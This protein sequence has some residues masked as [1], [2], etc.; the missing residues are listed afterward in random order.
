MVKMCVTYLAL[1]QGLA[2]AKASACG[3]P[4]KCEDFESAAIVR[5]HVVHVQCKAEFTRLLWGFPAK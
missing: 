1:A 4:A 2:F 3:F 5:S